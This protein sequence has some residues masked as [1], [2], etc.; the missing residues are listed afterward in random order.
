MGTLDF[1][2]PPAVLIPVGWS[3]TQTVRARGKFYDERGLRYRLRDVGWF[4]VLYVDGLTTGRVRLTAAQLYTGTFSW[5]EITYRTKYGLQTISNRIPDDRPA[6]RRAKREAR[7]GNQRIAE[8]RAES[9]REDRELG[10]DEL[11]RVSLCQYNQNRASEVTALHE[12]EQRLE[13]AS[14]ARDSADSKVP[15]A[16]FSFASQVYEALGMQPPA[17]AATKVEDAMAVWESV[18]RLGG[19]TAALDAAKHAQETLGEGHTL[20]QLVRAAPYLP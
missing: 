16:A 5:E 7:A 10:A 15:L 1:A 14:S 4:V 6:W 20:S 11:F 19:T 3:A 17:D 2:D 8:N 13:E 18:R 9:R 12:A